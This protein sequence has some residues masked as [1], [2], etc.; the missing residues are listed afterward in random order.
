MSPRTVADHE[1]PDAARP[2]HP[3]HRGS[4]VLFTAGGRR[5]A[6]PGIQVAEVARVA[7]FTPLPSDDGMILGVAFHR[8]RVVPVI[9]AAR[10]LGLAHPVGAPPWLCLFVRGPAGEMGVPVDAV[11]GF[12]RPGGPWAA[13]AVPVVDLVELPADAAHPAD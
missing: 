8:D 13:A 6:V 12:E 10:R 2:R 4:V 1:V 11:L 7:A 9:D 5:F 3:D